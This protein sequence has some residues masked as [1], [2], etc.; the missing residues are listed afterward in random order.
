MKGNNGTASN[1][2]KGLRP[3][4]RHVRA[5]KRGL[6]GHFM[7]QYV[8]SQRINRDAAGARN[9]TRVPLPLYPA[10]CRRYSCVRY[11][12]GHRSQ[13]PRLGLTFV[14]TLS[15]VYCSISCSG[16]RHLFLFTVTKATHIFTFMI[17][18]RWQFCPTLQITRPSM[19]A[20]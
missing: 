12:S 5:D 17:L 9:L 16:Q 7:I 3:G 14:R 10:S 15:L 13:S 6:G 18:T 2:L 20:M 11:N 19:K 1:M 8:V 4:R